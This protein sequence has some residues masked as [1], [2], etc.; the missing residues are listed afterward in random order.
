MKGSP[1]RVRA[2]ASS[3][4]LQI[5]SFHEEGEPGSSE[6]SL[7]GQVVGRFGDPEARVRPR[8]PD[9]HRRDDENPNHR[10][11]YADQV[12]VASPA[13]VPKGERRRM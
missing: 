11:L 2:S 10:K 3:K 4:A 8:R 12:Y 9:H 1:V 6:R 5:A 7:S 13:W